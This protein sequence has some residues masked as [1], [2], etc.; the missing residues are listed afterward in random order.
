MVAPPDHSLSTVLLV[1]PQQKCQDAGGK[2]EDDVHDAKRPARFQHRTILIN[3]GAPGRAVVVLS[4]IIP[5]DPEVDVDIARREVRARGTS[6]SSQLVDGGY[7]SGNEGEVDKSDEVGRATGGGES[8]ESCEG[9]GAG[10]NRDD[11][12]DE[13]KVRCQLALAVVAIDEPCL[14]KWY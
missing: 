8:E 6:D 1:P 5:K 9:P 3:V 10:E 11:E 7:E 14:R 4:S 12:E 13:N 2:E